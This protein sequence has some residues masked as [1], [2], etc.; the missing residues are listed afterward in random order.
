MTFL[1]SFKVLF[2]LTDKHPICFF[3]VYLQMLYLFV[4]IVKEVFSFCGLI[5]DCLYIEK[6]LIFIN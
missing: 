1:N 5:K 2:K 6:L 4:T 3:E